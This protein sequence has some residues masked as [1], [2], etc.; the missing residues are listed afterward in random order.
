MPNLDPIFVDEAPTD[1]FDPETAL[2]QMRERPVQEAVTALDTDPNKIDRAY[3]LSRAT[4]VNPALVYADVDNFDH[5]TKVQLTSNIIRENDWLREYI[6]R[7]PTVTKLSAD[8][9]GNLDTFTEKLSAF[10]KTSH[11]GILGMPT[12]AADAAWMAAWKGFREGVGE[13][14]IG[15]WTETVPFMKNDLF[16]QKMWA[17]AGS[18]IEVPF[19]LLGGV[20]HGATEATLAGAEV[21]YTGLTGD[22]QGASRF[23]RD[24]AGIVEQQMTGQGVHGA[25]GD[26]AA[27]AKYASAMRKAKLWLDNGVEPP[28]GIDP[29]IDRAKKEQNDV[30]VANLEDTLKAAEA[31]ATR[32]RDPTTFAD[33]VRMRDTGTIAIDGD[34]VL[35]LYGDKSPLPE[36]GLLGWAPRIREQIELARA[37]GGDI[38]IPLA[39]WLAYADGD[40]MKSLR[41]D[42]RVRPGGIT[43]NEAKLDAE[44]QKERIRFAAIKVDDAIYY[45]ATHADA[46]ARFTNETGKPLDYLTNQNT[47]EGFLTTNKR[48]V[49]RKEAAKLAQDAE[50]LIEGRTP[51]FKGKIGEL[52]AVDI[53]ITKRIP[54]KPKEIL[55]DDLP[56]IR[57]AG[58]LE[59]MFS[60]GDRKLKLERR[61]A[62]KVNVNADGS[63]RSDEFKLLD[64]NGQNVGW[65]EVIPYDGGKRLYIDNIGGMESKGYGP[66]SFGNS[67]TRDIARQ[68]K[69]EYPQ[70][71]MVGGY[72]ISGAREKAGTEREVWIKFDEALAD[73]MAFRDILR[74]GEWKSMGTG[75]EAYV[76]PEFS[77]RERE[78]IDAIETERKRLTPKQV[79]VFTPQRIR[80]EDTKQNIRGVFTQYTDRNPWISVA[81]DSNDPIGVYRHEAIHNLRRQGFFTDVEWAVLERAARDGDWIT[82][83]GIDRR[84]AKLD[85]AAK[86]EEAIADGFRDW[87]RDAESVPA[88]ARPVYARLKE[89]FDAIKLRL[90]EIF[91]RDLEWNEIF[92]RVDEGKVGSRKGTKP[93]HEQAYRESIEPKFSVDEEPTQPPP[94][95]RTPGTIGMSAREHN[96]RERRMQEQHEADIA[97]EQ[98]KAEREQR[99][100]QTAEW[101]TEKKNVRAE[102]EAD[103][104]QRPDVAAD[105]YFA[106]GEIYGEKGPK[107]KMDPADVPEELRGALP[108]DWFAKPG[109]EAVNLEDVASLAGYST[110]RAMLE[111]LARYNTTKLAANMSAKAFRDRMVELEV[112]RRMTERFGNLEENILDAV[113]DHVT[114]TTELNRLSDDVLMLG[115]KAGLTAPIMKA[116]IKNAMHDA[117]EEMPLAG[118]SSDKYLRAAGKLGTASEIHDLKGEHDSAYREKQ[119]QYH[120]MVLMGETRTLEKEQKKLAKLMRGLA[121]RDVKGLDNEFH[122]VLQMLMWQAG[123]P[124]RRSLP[125]IQ[126]SM[127]KSGYTGLDSFVQSLIDDG[128]SPAVTDNIK[129]GFVKPM[130][131]MTVGEFREFKTAIESLNTIGRDTKK[132]NVRG[133]KMEFAAYEDEVVNRITSTRPLRSDK[134]QGN[135][136]YQID[137]ALTRPENLL[138]ALDFGEEMGSLVDVIVRPMAKS[139]SYEY[140]LEEKLSDDIKALSV[141]KQWARTLKETLPNNIIIDP[142]TSEPFLITRENFIWILLNRGNRGNKKVMNYSMASAALG[143]KANRAEAEAFGEKLDEWINAHARKEDLDYVQ[144]VWDINKGFRDQIDTV[145]RN[146]SGTNHKFVEAEPFETKFGTYDGGYWPLIRNKLLSGDLGKG[147]SDDALFGSD[148]FNAATP[149]SYL[150]ERTGAV[151]HIDF[152]SPLSM[153][154]NRLQQTIHDIAYRDSIMNAAKVMRSP[155]IRSAIA[156][157]YGTEYLPHIDKA[158]KDQARGAT[159]DELNNQGI[160]RVLRYFRMNL[161]NHALPFN[162]KVLATPDI[163][164]P[165]PQS[166]MN[167][168]NGSWKQNRELADKL[169]QETPH[170]I[171]NM[172]RDF[173]EAMQ[174][175]VGEGKMDS[176]KQ[177]AIRWGYSV[178]SWVSR[179]FRRATFLHEYNRALSEGHE[180]AKAAAIA[181]S[182]VR[183]RHSA[184]SLFDL[185]SIM[186]G[187]EKARMLTMFY[188]YANTMYNWQR[189]IPDQ[190][191]RAEYFEAMKTATGSLLIGSIF[192][193]IVINNMKEDDT[194]LKQFGKAIPLQLLST[195]PFAREG[196]TMMMEGIPPSTAYGSAIKAF[197]AM[198]NNAKKLYNKQPVEKPIKDIANLLGI[199]FGGVGTLQI[200]RTGQGLYDVAVGKQKPRNIFEWIRLGFTGEARLKR[201][202]ER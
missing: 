35:R 25:F 98:A 175:A 196:V 17:A 91:G 105:I 2:Q 34:A 38:E 164:L 121:K 92:Q 82:K 169:S 132:I 22:E 135:L 149:Q 57:A 51:Q 85:P 9:W 36:D 155:R 184:V 79:D 116:D 159:I 120:A 12:R 134:S 139:K 59:P 41:D 122:D 194:W 62:G 42:I 157:Y 117:F 47:T 32:Q 64:E 137:A 29:L 16:M 170:A 37:S 55:P 171:Y 46:V 109:A 14:P 95:F 119:K 5:Q 129:A 103:F 18:P 72:R 154:P 160:D 108:K 81:L 99:R 106:R 187:G 193:A 100:Q 6:T 24:L 182:Y 10:R 78:I 200:G 167:Y 123:I 27:F 15:G 191:R 52:D 90:K 50:Q 56:T 111:D 185:P 28:K 125:E 77:G 71:E 152:Q 43:K 96:L 1:E 166:M 45:G 94:L 102:V 70:A 140:T 8:D 124:S 89:L 198:A 156:N 190:V 199:G 60:I 165:S 84:Y 146:T 178:V 58:G 76:K 173:R 177:D 40:L 168:F 143:R 80:R 65:V 13:G 97:Y 7:N 115:N 181:D 188:G 131:Q 186:R 101:R 87:K 69:G 161:V 183:E 195:I 33:L 189:N 113:K 4:G 180:S 107:P 179:E 49:D 19:R 88:A 44:Q 136:M 202:G 75:L 3:K 93:L 201:Q 147:L 158:I 23:A 126:N 141:S 20:I 148:Y 192:G 127:A 197:S 150:K 151:Y 104:D 162:Y 48:Y 142:R 118:Q 21:A 74:G 83:Y 145:G 53:D 114:G 30:D 39:D 130:G 128:W 11:E 73:P 172:D 54:T 66:N 163:G 63:I 112:D 61:Q 174:K 31:S 110:A 144:G 133:E 86:L 176:A 68:L 67:L 138:K 153:I 26:A